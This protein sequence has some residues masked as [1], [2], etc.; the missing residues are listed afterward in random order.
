MHS[1]GDSIILMILFLILTYYRFLFYS[2][3]SEYVVFIL[4]VI[5]NIN[6]HT[7]A[8]LKTTICLGIAELA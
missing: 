6:T 3:S 5:I 8:S 1:L 4:S 7:S 2:P